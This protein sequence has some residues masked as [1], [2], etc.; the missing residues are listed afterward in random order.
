MRNKN[1]F[2]ILDFGSQ[3]TNLIKVNLSK[4]GYLST[5]IAGDESF[6]VFKNERV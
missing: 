6:S 1:V 3:Y 2:V 4:M 5:I